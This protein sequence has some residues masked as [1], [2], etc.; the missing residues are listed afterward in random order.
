MT[1]P[2]PPGYFNC[3]PLAHY[4]KQ[5]LIAFSRVV[6]EE[7]VQSAMSLQSAPIKKVVTNAHT[8]RQAILRQGPFDGDASMDAMCSYTQISTS[9]DEIADFFRMESPQKL[10]TYGD[11]LGQTI[12]DRRT[13]Y[14]LVD[15]APAAT[16][17]KRSQRCDGKSPVHYVGVEWWA[18]DASLPGLFVSRDTCVVECHDEF[19]YF[20]AATRKVCRGFIRAFNSV[21]MDCCPSMKKSHGLVRGHIKRSGHI[22]IETE[23]PGTYDYYHVLTVQPNGLVPRVAANAFMQR[24]CVRILNLEQ[25]FQMQRLHPPTGKLSMG[26]RPSETKSLG[27][28]LCHRPFGLFRLKHQCNQCDEMVCTNCS[29]KCNP[30]PHPSS[31]TTKHRVCHRCFNG[32]VSARRA[33]SRFSTLASTVL[34]SRE[35][36]LSSDGAVPPNS[37]VLQSNRS[38]F[39]HVLRQSLDLHDDPTRCIV[40]E[41]VMP[42]YYDGQFAFCSSPTS[43]VITGVSSNMLSSFSSYADSVVGVRDV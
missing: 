29:L 4:E 21:D 10:R 42:Q 8:K 3:P 19:E 39:D 25:H 2:L 36:D 40:Q 17:S 9:I 27:C 12:L 6:C 16:V 28:L 11:V 24:Q 35:S 5:Q 32:G 22:F 41:M 1:L 20:D 26:T 43:S 38:L 33:L 37:I 18:S 7:T 31:G 30:T 14:T 13:L 15:R 23:T 34:S